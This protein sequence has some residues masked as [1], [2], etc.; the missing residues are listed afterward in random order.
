MRVNIFPVYADGVVVVLDC[1]VVI[2]KSGTQMSESD[3]R[4]RVF[5][6]VPCRFFVVR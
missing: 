1:G 4:E 3:M 6:I 2:A 5:V